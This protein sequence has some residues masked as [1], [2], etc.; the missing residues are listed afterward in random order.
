MSYA[1]VADLPTAVQRALTAVKYGRADIEVQ[2]S[3]TVSLS[4][5][6]GSGT[7]GFAVLVNLTTGQHVISWGSWGG[8]NMFNPTNAVDLDTRPYALP[9]DGVAITGSIGGGRPTYA[10][11]KIPASM[12]ALMLPAPGPALSKVE[13]DALYCHSAYKGGQGRRDE[14]ARRRVPS[15]VVDAMVERGYLKRNKA[16]ATAITT[17]GRNAVGNY[18]GY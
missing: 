4:V 17:D 5:G 12:V 9:A 13:L 6:G 2:A 14:L 15:S 8:A 7:K 1:K 16:G 3:E 11:V 10:V 18:R